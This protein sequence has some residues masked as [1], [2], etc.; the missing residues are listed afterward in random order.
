MADQTI[1]LDKYDEET[2]AI[3]KKS[4]GVLDKDI[5]VDKEAKRIIKEDQPHLD[6]IPKLP[7]S[8]QAY[9]KNL[10]EDDKDRVLRYLDI[11]RG[12]VGI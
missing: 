8:Y 1:Q 6:N 7:S 12:Y 2:R 4:L 3:L 9:V 5:D 11:F 10:P